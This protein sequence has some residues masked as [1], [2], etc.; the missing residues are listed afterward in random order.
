[1]GG[2]AVEAILGVAL[3]AAVELEGVAVVADVQRRGDP[4]PTDA[5]ALAVVGGNLEAQG[6]RVAEGGVR[7]AGAIR[8]AQ[9]T[10]AG[11]PICQSCQVAK[12]PQL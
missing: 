1:M 4:V 6:T 9:E 8:E 11:L 3:E 7:T 10:A 12:V 2:Y 5:L